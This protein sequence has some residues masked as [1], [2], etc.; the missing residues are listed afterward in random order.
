MTYAQQR[1]MH[2][3]DAHLMEL[4]DCLD[5]YLDKRTRERLHNA[6][7]FQRNRDFFGFMAHGPSGL[8]GESK[9]D[10]GKRLAQLHA[11]EPFRAD[12]ESNL[13]QRKN[14]SGFG[15]FDVRDRSQALDLLGFRSQLLFST[16]CLA[17]FYLEKGE[18]VE[19]QYAAAQAHNRM[20]ADFC[21]SDP[22]LLPAGFVPLDDFDRAVA[23]AKQA[24]EV[25][26]KALRIPATCPKSHS[27]SHVALEPVWAIAQEANLPIVFH[28]DG[29]ELA[30]KTYEVNGR[31]PVPDVMGGDSTHTSVSY[32]TVYVDVMNTLS[33]LIF[34]G[35]M[36]KFPNLKFGVIELGAGWVPSWLYLMDSTLR[37]FGRLEDRLQKLSAP[38]SEIARRQ[39]RLTAFHHE[40]VSWIIENSG[41][42]M[43]M[44]SSDYPHIEGG[45]N[46]LKRFDDFLKNAPRQRVD[47]FYVRN[48]EDL[49]GSGLA[50]QLRVKAAA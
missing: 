24:I 5:A 42:E 23:T 46:P 29:L 1:I 45:R 31:P 13:M 32:M 17:N 22:R 14:Y 47:N 43:I 9:D 41:D 6:S 16:F 15:A 10:W 18:D 35:V 25:G 38:P 8:E 20:M 40:D 3:A 36:D 26:C 37:A 19:L 28:T 27:P 39:V 48:F 7:G 50:S 30:N 2:D 33:S 21:S 11:S 4:P 49:M 34:D 12:I 44:F